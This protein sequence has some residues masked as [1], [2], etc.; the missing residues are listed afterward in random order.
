M[1]NSTD[2]MLILQS[3]VEFGVQTALQAVDL[4]FTAAV[5]LCNVERLSIIN[6]SGNTYKSNFI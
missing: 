5:N 4:G 6:I 2:L 1:Y 3:A